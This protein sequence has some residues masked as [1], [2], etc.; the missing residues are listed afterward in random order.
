LE[1]IIVVVHVGAVKIYVAAV[2]ALPGKRKDR[3]KTTGLLLYTSY[4]CK[5]LNNLGFTMFRPMVQESLNIE[6]FYY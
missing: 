5:V 4:Y 3:V 1:V 6:Q 2:E